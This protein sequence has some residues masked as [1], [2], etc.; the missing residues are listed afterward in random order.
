VTPDERAYYST[1][2]KISDPGERTAV[3]TSQGRPVA[4]DV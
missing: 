2:G 1:H 3:V 4:V